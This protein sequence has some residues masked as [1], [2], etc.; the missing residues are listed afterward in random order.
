[1]CCLVNF[2]PF[3]PKEKIYSISKWEKWPFENVIFRQIPEEML[4]YKPRRTTG[5]S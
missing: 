2:R 5:M 3:Q 1:M 4:Y